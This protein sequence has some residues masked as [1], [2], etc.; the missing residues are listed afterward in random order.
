MAQ[1]RIIKTTD[2]EYMLERHAAQPNRTAQEIVAY[3]TRLLYKLEKAAEA[4]E[5][6]L[7]KLEKLDPSSVA[8]IQIHAAKADIRRAIRRID[9]GLT[10]LCR[11][12]GGND[13]A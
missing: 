1:D 2:F 11:G 4:V 5:V 6:E 3:M 9:D 12:P 10:A 13:K 7:R 8:W